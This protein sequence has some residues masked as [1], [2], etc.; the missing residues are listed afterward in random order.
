MARCPVPRGSLRLDHGRRQFAE[1][2]PLAEMARNSKAGPIRS[3]RSPRAKPLRRRKPGRAG[4][5]RGPYRGSRRSLP[6]L[7]RAAGLGFPARAQIAIIVDGAARLAAPC[8]NQGR[9]DAF[10]EIQQTQE[11]QEAEKR[12][13]AQA[14]AENKAPGKENAQAGQTP[15]QEWKET[16][17]VLSLRKNPGSTGAGATNGKDHTL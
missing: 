8:R 6:P 1:F 5:G 13:E 9:D 10:Q 12:Q 16:D 7:S 15:A 17:L 2:S 11:T 3:R 14:C 4:L